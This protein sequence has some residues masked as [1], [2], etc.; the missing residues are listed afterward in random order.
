MSEVEWCILIKTLILTK[1]KENYKR[2]DLHRN[3]LLFKLL[4]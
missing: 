2:L 4:M 3:D 1:R